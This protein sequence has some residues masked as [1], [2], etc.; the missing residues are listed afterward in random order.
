MSLV[1]RGAPPSEHETPCFI[2][3]RKGLNWF[4]AQDRIDPEEA[5]YRVNTVQ[6]FQ[7]EQATRLGQTQQ[8]SG[9][10]SVRMIQRMELPASGSATRFWSV[11]TEWAGPAAEALA[12]ALFAGLVGYFA[13][14][15][16]RKR[17]S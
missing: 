4:D 15:V 10:G 1:Y 12:F 13:W 17:V 3:G 8:Y 11:G 7:G 6:N 5:L 2:P 14:L 9:L 16:T